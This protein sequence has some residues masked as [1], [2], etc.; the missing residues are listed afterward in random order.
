[1]R[2]LIYKGDVIIIYEYKDALSLI[3]ELSDIY[4]GDVTTVARGGKGRHKIEYYNYPCSF[5]I[6]TTTIKPGELD[7]SAP[8]DAPPLGFPYLFQWNIYGRVIMCRTY[9]E[10]IDIFNWIAEYFHTSK[11]RRLVIFDHN[12]GYEE[13]FFRG[14]WE[15]DSS[16]CFALDEHHPVTIVLKNGLMI[17]DSYKLTNMS[18]ELLSKDWAK[19]WVKDKTIMDYSKLRTPYTKLSDNE[20]I[21]SALDVL[22]LS[23]SVM[24]YLKGQGANIWTRCPTATSFIRAEYKK[25]I[26]ISAKHWTDE[27]KEYH[28]LLKKCAVNEKQFKLL[29]RLA[30]GGNT[31][32]NRAITG[33]LL[34]DLVHFDIT[35]SYPA[36]MV[37]YPEYPINAWQPMDIGAE[38]STLELFEANGYC[39]MADIILIDPKLK[40][41]VT[42]PYI[43]ISKMVP[44]QGFG[45]NYSDN[46]RYLG[47]LDA[48]QISIFGIEWP[49]IKAQYDFSDAYITEGYFA[50]KGYLP[51]IL[52]KFILKYYAAKTELKRIQGKEVEY[53][54]S[55][56][57][58]NGI[59]GMAFT[60]PIRG[61][62]IMTE[63]GIVE[64]P[65]KSIEEELE[66]YQKSKSYFL[67]YAWGAM[68]A[69]LGRVYLQKMIDALG[70]AF[71]YGDTDSAFAL[72]PAQ[73]R[74]RIRKLEKEITEYQR[75][76]GL[77]LTYYD[78]KG[79]PHELGSIS[80]EPYCKYFKTFG[81]KKYITVENDKLTCT[82]AGVP[83]RGGA[84]IIGKPERF[85][86]GLNFEGSKTGKN[87]LWYNEDPGFFLHDKRG[88][89]I[90]IHNNIAMLPCD[91]LLSLS[92]DY[93]ECLSIEGNF[94]WNFK[95]LKKS[96]VVNE[97]NY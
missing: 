88:R 59:F 57:K 35:S 49:I 67:P 93:T 29:L 80:E 97:E 36:Q 83:K 14:I 87:C 77:E 90:E 76:C 92:R 38:L 3:Q 25:L 40:E 16:E 81:A 19:H 17:R 62:F 30:R 15:L 48:I 28:K 69:A 51:D 6:E 73:S 1:M 41:G 42:T 91:Y 9:P 96:G 75:R 64:E 94:H 50:K 7:Y 20:Y 46:G 85:R 21:Y 34:R 95:E 74:Q 4:A 66:K 63:A 56:T 45:L 58:V 37:C 32:A 86:L 43:S 55:K 8:A 23:D 47:G 44:V 2:R 18:L 12:A 13:M 68:T 33:R 5:D 53:A 11:S 54:I 65:P 22:A 10:A 31:H 60:N 82:I 27:Q 84:R 72:H 89:P 24:E 39:T 71:C 78:K 79:K 26:G 52:R 61:R 70:P